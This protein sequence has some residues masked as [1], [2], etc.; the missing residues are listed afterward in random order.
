MQS[1][2]DGQS[3]VGVILGLA[4]VFFVVGLVLLL[5]FARSLVSP[6]KHA[7]LPAEMVVVV[8]TWLLAGVLAAAPA[9]VDDSFA[10]PM[11][12]F[13]LVTVVMS[14]SYFAKGIGLVDNPNNPFKRE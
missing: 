10:G 11:Q 14:V 6:E 3:N 2:N 13:A 7:L 12:G 8:I 4:F 9:W 5:V 1:T